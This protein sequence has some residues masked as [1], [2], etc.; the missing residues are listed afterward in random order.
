MNRST[1]VEPNGVLLIDKPEGKTSH[2][3]VGAVRRLYHT[4]KVGH[5][6]TLDPLATGVLVVLIGRA[7]KAA[8]YL[9]SDS[10][11]Y[12]ATLRL[13]LVT[14][15][16]DITG[17]V[18]KKSDVLPPPE[19]VIEVAN[20]FLGTY[21]QTPPM[22]SALKVN[23]QKLVDL[24]RR[25]IEIE[26]EARAVEIHSISCAPLSADTY[27]LEVSCSAGT[28]IRTLCADIGARLGCGGVMAT[29]RR[30]K[31]GGFPLSECTTLDALDALGDEERL[32]HLI[33]IESLFAALP[34]LSLPAFFE[35]L[36]RNGCEIYQSK[37]KSNLPI[38][39]RVRL[40]GADGTFF[41][42]GE[43]REYPAGSAVKAIKFFDV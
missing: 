26:R 2:D 7:A 14:D 8:E 18:L 23:G 34:A 1:S 21:L 38:G 42:L 32:A 28:Y 35:K 43:V 12:H 27:T 24:A 4:R 19:R 29:L 5:T 31:T 16:E 17:T 33:P 30:H 41:A 25:G 13:G 40:L 3:V 22:Y 9:S 11:V 37:I 20:S 39:T 10:K 36:S 6:G 15:T